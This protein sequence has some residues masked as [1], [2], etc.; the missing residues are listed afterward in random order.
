MPGAN[1]AVSSSCYFLA[2]LKNDGSS[3]NF[4]GVIHAIEGD[5]ATTQCPD[6][7]WDGSPLLGGGFQSRELH[8]ARAQTRR[9]GLG[10]V[11]SNLH[12]FLLPEKARTAM[13]MQSLWVMR[14]KRGR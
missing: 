13:L 10:L 7:M 8:N 4:F 12:R 9:N 1:C 6:P 5:Q 3:L 2:S 14:Q 11:N